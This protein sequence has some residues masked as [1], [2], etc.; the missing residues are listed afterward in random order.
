[1][2]L[3]ICHYFFVIKIT[4]LVKL[5]RCETRSMNTTSA[6]ED[7]EKLK[8]GGCKQNGKKFINKIFAAIF[9]EMMVNGETTQFVMGLDS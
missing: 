6:L 5:Q 2:D 1:M 4:Y 3:W 9:H 7:L 8:L